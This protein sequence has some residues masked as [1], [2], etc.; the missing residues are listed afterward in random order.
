MPV[1]E[2][3]F[4][5]RELRLLFRVRRANVFVLARELLVPTLFFC[6][7]SDAAVFPL[8]KPE[9]AGPGRDLP[10]FRLTNS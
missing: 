10:F 9:K 4:F 6:K 1:D 5:V 3:L 2:A 7:H 8:M